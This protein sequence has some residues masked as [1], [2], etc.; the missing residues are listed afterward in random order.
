MLNDI[1]NAYFCFCM[2]TWSTNFT[3]ISHTKLY[4]TREYKQYKFVQNY[5]FDMYTQQLIRKMHICHVDDGM[6]NFTT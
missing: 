6:L 3:K 5:V 2:S 1:K 4:Q